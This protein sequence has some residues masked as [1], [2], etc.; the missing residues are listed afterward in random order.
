MRQVIENN[1]THP[2]LY[3]ELND[4]RIK[5]D[6]LVGMSLQSKRKFIIFFPKLH[7]Y[8]FHN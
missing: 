2:L 7:I 3:I 5:S 8:H 4:T 6:Q 1:K